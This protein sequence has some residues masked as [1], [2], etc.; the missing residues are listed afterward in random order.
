MIHAL[1]AFIFL[2]LLATI[3]RHQQQNPLKK[4][5]R[6]DSQESTASSNASALTLFGLTFGNKS[7]L[8]KTLQTNSQSQMANSREIAADQKTDP[9]ATPIG[10]GKI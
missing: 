4:K 5:L 1:I 6:S 9:P 8:L 7:I 2:Q 10:E 3:V